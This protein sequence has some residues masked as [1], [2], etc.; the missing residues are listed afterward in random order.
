MACSKGQVPGETCLN[1]FASTQPLC[2]KFREIPLKGLWR[3]SAFACVA[4]VVVCSAWQGLFLPETCLQ[5]H[6]ANQLLGR[7][8]LCTLSWKEQ[9]GNYFGLSKEKA[10]PGKP[11]F[12]SISKI[13]NFHVQQVSTRVIMDFYHQWWYKCFPSISSLTRS[14]IQV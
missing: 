11:F 2:I 6:K 5:P 9:M 4:G 7:R 14:F 12:Y 1:G 8:S 10:G 3:S 13:I